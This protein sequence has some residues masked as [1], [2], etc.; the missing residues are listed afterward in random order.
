MT[1]RIAQ[2][3]RRLPKPLERAATRKS[4]LKPSASFRATRQESN[5][6]P[7]QL[8]QDEIRRQAERR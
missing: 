5:R 3:S 1:D 8:I 6:E 7:L 2:L 4:G